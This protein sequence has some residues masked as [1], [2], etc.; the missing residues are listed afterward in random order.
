[1]KY[2]SLL[3]AGLKKWS[4]HIEIWKLACWGIGI[5][6]YWSIGVR[7]YWSIGVMKNIY[8]SLCFFRPLFHYSS[9]PVLSLLFLLLIP[10]SA[11]AAMNNKLKDVPICEAGYNMTL[12]LLLEA[13]PPV[14]DHYTAK[15]LERAQQSIIYADSMQEPFADSGYMS[16]LDTAYEA[17]SM[18]TDTNLRVI[19][20]ERDLLENTTC[21]HIDLFLIETMMEKVRCK[22]IQAFDER[23]HVAIMILKDTIHSLN[24]RYAQLLQGARDNAYE[25]GTWKE[26]RMSDPPS[27]VAGGEEKKWCKED[28]DCTSGETCFN[29]R[30]KQKCKKDENCAGYEECL[31]DVCE[32]RKMC[33]FHSDYLPPSEVGRMEDGDDE[34][35]VVRYGC[36]P[37][38]LDIYNNLDFEFTKIG[39]TIKKE[40]TA[41]EET[42][43]KRNEF[44][45]DSTGLMSYALFIET[46][47][48]GRVSGS[49]D[50]LNYFGMNAGD[51]I[52]HVVQTGCYN[53][54]NKTPPVLPDDIDHNTADYDKFWPPFWPKGAIRW[55]TYG[56]FSFNR[57]DLRLLREFIT[58][59]ETWGRHRPIYYELP[60]DYGILYFAQ[61]WIRG[62]LKLWDINQEKISSTMETRA[63]DMPRQ[64]IEELKPL[65]E[66]VNVI[67]SA[68]YEL[69]DGTIRGF[70]MRLA[71]FLRRSCMDRPCND[72]LERILKVSFQDECFPYT[73]GDY[74][75]G[76]N[77]WE[78]CLDAADIN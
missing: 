57:D 72:R 70:A 36:D 13:I 46:W 15:V 69:N 47:L 32:E 33:P 67:S 21:L 58:L 10:A 73:K 60:E 20:R 11:S 22:L 19:Q 24:E 31:N 77:L 51:D 35:V 29:K 48:R 54:N 8:L 50:R 3:K 45:N 39:E 4:L 27:F 63:T 25:D 71:Y 65:R 42:L 14:S 52:E 16:W 6:E 75:N 78:G 44:I 18:I 49:T 61:L 53:K 68:A 56:P 74:K 37:E 23:R 59:R 64:I 34:L 55:E 40:S 66:S 41:I 43:E 9:I 17:F 12:E 62:Q 76:G 7:E 5:L 38:V 2:Y 1:M 26:K 28:E 30:C